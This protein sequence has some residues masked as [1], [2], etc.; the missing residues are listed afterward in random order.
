MRSGWPASWQNCRA[1]KTLRV[2]R[3]IDPT[4]DPT[5]LST[6]TPT[7]EKAPEIILDSGGLELVA[8][9]GFDTVETGRIAMLVPWAA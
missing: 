4:I 5:S 2:R 8:G 7:H 3:R 6:R 1:E 9:T